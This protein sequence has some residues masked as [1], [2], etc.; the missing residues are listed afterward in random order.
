M[1]PS[2]MKLFEIV[3]KLRK[4]RYGLVE[5]ILSFSIKQSRVKPMMNHK[6]KEINDRIIFDFSIS[7]I[8]ADCQKFQDSPF[9]TMQSTNFDSQ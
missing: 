1:N 2:Q 9:G 3:V 7:S 6:Q 8:F 4:S 5:Q